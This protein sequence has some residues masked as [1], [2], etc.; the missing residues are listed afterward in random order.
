MDAASWSAS[1]PFIIT[2]LFGALA[3]WF[4]IRIEV[5]KTIAEIRRERRKTRAEL[6]TEIHKADGK[7]DAMSARPSESEIKQ[8]ELRGAMSI[9]NRQTRARK[10]KTD[11]TADA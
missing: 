1:L 3:L 7:L 11:P 4:A 8:A 10:P 2:F 9:L 5:D 6:K